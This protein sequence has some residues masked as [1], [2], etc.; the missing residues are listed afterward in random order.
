M[1]GNRKITKL[2]RFDFEERVLI[3]IGWLAN[4]NTGREPAHVIVKVVYHF[5]S[6]YNYNGALEISLSIKDVRKSGGSSKS[7]RPHLVQNVT[8]LDHGENRDSRKY[9]YMLR[10]N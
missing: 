6:E 3:V 5:R 8:L 9:R 4:S 2:K 1:I 7:G 10:C